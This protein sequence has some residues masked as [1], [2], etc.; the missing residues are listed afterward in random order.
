LPDWDL[1]TESQK[2]KFIDQINSAQSDQF[3]PIFTQVQQ[4]IKKVKDEKLLLAE[5]NLVIQEIEQL[6][7]AD[8]VINSS[9]LAA[10][11]SN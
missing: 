8:P 4:A 5:K 2:Q 3:S 9:E 10:N 6:L 1:L 11:N 7:L